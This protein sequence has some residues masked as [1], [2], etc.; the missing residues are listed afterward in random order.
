MARPKRILW[1][2]DEVDDCLVKPVHPRQILSVV[3]RLL[4]GDRIRQQRIARDFVARFREL[5]GRRGSTLAWREWIEFVVELSRWEVRLAASNEPGLSEALRA[6]QASLRKDF[7]GRSEE[8]T[9]ELQSL[10]YLVC[11]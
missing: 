9:S 6:L 4:E 5:E 10:A 2:D 3:T 8:H 11:R 7:A 1:V